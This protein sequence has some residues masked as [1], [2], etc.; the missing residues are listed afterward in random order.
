MCLKVGA[1]LNL[2]LEDVI[3]DDEENFRTTREREGIHFVAGDLQR[4]YRVK[5]LDMYVKKPVFIEKTVE[6]CV[7][8]L[9]KWLI[10]A[11]RM[12]VRV[13]K[14]V[15]DARL[16]SLEG[17]RVRRLGRVSNRLARC[18]DF[19]RIRMKDGERK[20]KSRQGAN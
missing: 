2:L 20:T 7:C 8:Y 5:Y 16:G 13:A 10:K 17:L 15:S 11:A 14:A 19:S 3:W 4:Q 1:N 18:F 9:D 6:L 12:R